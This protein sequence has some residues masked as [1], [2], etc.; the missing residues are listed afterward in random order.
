MQGRSQPDRA[1]GEE[2][3]Q[4]LAGS[5]VEATHLIIGR[6]PEVGPTTGSHDMEGAVEGLARLHVEDLVPAVPLGLTL[7]RGLR[8]V[9]R[10]PGPGHHRDAGQNLGRDAA[11]GVVAPV[12]GPVGGTGGSQGQKGR[13]GDRGAESGHDADAWEGAFEEGLTHRPASRRSR[14]VAYRLASEPW[15]TSTTVPPDRR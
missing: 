12:G 11:A 13:R 3:P 10:L 7:P 2:A 5:G 1:L 6:R 14:W 9:L 15:V 8:R 4:D